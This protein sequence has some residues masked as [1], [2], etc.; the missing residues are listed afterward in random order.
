MDLKPSRFAVL[1]PEIPSYSSERYD[2]YIT[3]NLVENQLF[4][5]YSK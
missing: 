4:N 5:F 1:V 2:A 3:T